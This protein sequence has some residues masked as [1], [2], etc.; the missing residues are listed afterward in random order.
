MWEKG[1]TEAASLRGRWK[2]K[3]LRL[4]AEDQLASDR[5]KGERVGRGLSLKGTEQTIT[6]GFLF[7]LCSLP[8]FSS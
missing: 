4:E 1:E 8:G 5:G 6:Q 2:R 7:V 3:G